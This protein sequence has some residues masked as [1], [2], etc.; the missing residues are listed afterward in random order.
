MIPSC[1]FAAG[2]G[3]YEDQASDSSDLSNHEGDDEE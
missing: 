3:E 2:D 1:A